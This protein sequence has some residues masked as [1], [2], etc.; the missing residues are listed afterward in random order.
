MVSA[1]GFDSIPADMGM[2]YTLSQFPPGCTPCFVESFLSVT[3]TAGMAGHYATYESAV[4]GFGSAGQVKKKIP[5]KSK[6]P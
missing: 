1:C 6:K 3:S 2:L 5:N 4:H